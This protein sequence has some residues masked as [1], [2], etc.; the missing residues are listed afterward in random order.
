MIANST[1]DYQWVQKEVL[2]AVIHGG[3][4]PK[5]LVH[6]SFILLSEASRNISNKRTRKIV[7]ILASD[8]QKI[9]SEFPN[10]K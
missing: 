2:S 1:Q 3:L 6:L 8:V 7:E 10:G 4:T 9:E 5:E